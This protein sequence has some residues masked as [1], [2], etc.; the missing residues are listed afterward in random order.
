MRGVRRLLS[1]V[2][3]AAV[4][5]AGSFLL[6]MRTAMPA[7]PRAEAQL[8]EDLAALRA[9]LERFHADH[10]WYPGDPERDYNSSGRT[11]LLRRQLTE[12]TRDDGR[13]APRRDAEYTFGPYLRDFP[14]DPWTGSRRLILDQS[15]SRSLALLRQEV[16]AGNGGG[17]WYYEARTGNIVANFG[18]GRAASSH[19]RFATF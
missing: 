18:R 9:A 17:G 1:T 8:T 13:P 12:F 2:L 16:E 19:P 5:A 3:A 14:A 6:G 4:L 15:R 11:E 10:G 7:A